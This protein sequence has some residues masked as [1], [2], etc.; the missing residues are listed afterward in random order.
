MKYTWFVSC[1]RVMWRKTK[2]HVDVWRNSANCDKR[3][4]SKQAKV[5]FTHA[6]TRTRHEVLFLSKVIFPEI[7]RVKN[8]PPVDLDPPQ[9]MLTIL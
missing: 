1:P 4:L 8:L 6:T 7:F 2:L 9:P 3:R 5:T